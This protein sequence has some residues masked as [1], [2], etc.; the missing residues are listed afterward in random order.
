M[1]LLFLPPIFLALTACGQ[2]VM[3]VRV[4]IPVPCVTEAVEEPV[5]PKAEEDDGLFVRVRALLAEIE[6]RKGY[7]ARLKAVVAGCS[8]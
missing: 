2:K 4:P 8:Q 6:M 1:R 7:E 5:Y 3:E